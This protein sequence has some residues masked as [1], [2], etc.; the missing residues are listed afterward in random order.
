MLVEIIISDIK[1]TNTQNIFGYYDLMPYQ[2]KSIS[3]TICDWQTLCRQKNYTKTE[4]KTA[5]VLKCTEKIV[6]RK[7]G[8]NSYS[9]TNQYK[10]C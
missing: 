5:M 6:Q 7:S 3:A 8:A 1:S 4:E 2:L 9:S 10:Q